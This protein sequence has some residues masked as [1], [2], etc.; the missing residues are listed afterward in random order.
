MN[1][2]FSKIRHIQESN[3][4]L[5]KRLLESEETELRPIDDEYTLGTAIAQCYNDSRSGEETEKLI[6]SKGNSNKAKRLIEKIKK[7]FGQ[8][9]DFGDNPKKLGEMYFN[10]KSFVRSIQEICKK[11]KIPY[12]PRA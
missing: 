9:S 3:K 4:M 6:E 2:S 8:R 12:M 10:D 1:K 11:Y 7:L 5:E